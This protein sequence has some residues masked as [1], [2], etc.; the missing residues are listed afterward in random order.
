MHVMLQAP[1]AARAA[2]AAA[3]AS[4]PSHPLPPS[5][6]SAR[7]GRDTGEFGVGGGAG[8]GMMGMVGVGNLE[9]GRP[10]QPIVF[11]GQARASGGAPERAI[12]SNVA[13]HSAS[14]P[15][16]PPLHP[17]SPLSSHAASS[18]RGA[19]MTMPTS[20]ESVCGEEVCRV[21]PGIAGTPAEPVCGASTH[22]N[23]G[24]VGAGSPM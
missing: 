4:T 13:L 16:S 19:I 11:P 2:A 8:Q 20:V 23:S 7:V 15:T 10:P 1:R 12:V 17:T 6:L 21:G 22:T 14:P 18:N 3:V 5:G 24:L 9:G